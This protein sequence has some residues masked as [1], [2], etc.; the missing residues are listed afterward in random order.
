MLLSLIICA[1]GSCPSRIKMANLSM[2]DVADSWK[3]FAKMSVTTFSRAKQVNNPNS[4]VTKPQKTYVFFRFIKLTEEKLN[5]AEKTE[6]D[7]HF[8]NLV[9]RAEK[10]RDCTA[11]ITAR[12]SAL[13][14]PNPSKLMRCYSYE[15][16]SWTIYG[17]SF[18]IM[19]YCGDVMFK[20]QIYMIANDNLLLC[21]ACFIQIR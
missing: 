20:V 1:A 8:E 12:T 14:Q 19:I 16:S 18:R 3:K 2:N 15:L 10:T 13:I 4:S 11:K 17:K 9:A 6:F 21:E 5:R 7:A